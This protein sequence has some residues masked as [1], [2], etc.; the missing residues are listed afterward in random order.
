MIRTK[1]SKGLRVTRE[2]KVGI[3]TYICIYRK[4]LANTNLK[5]LHYRRILVNG[6]VLKLCRN[7]MLQV[8]DFVWSNT[9]YPR[10]RVKFHFVGITR[11]SHIFGPNSPHNISVSR[12]KLCFRRH[13]FCAG[14]IWILEVIYFNENKLLSFFF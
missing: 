2:R 9:S 3:L 14:N 10:N 5:S 1:T 11:R 7:N 8:N 4:P 6:C 13:I 12:Q